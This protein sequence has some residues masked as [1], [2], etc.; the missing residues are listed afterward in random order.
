MNKNNKLKNST[1]KNLNFITN[2]KNTMTIFIKIKINN[3][4]PNPKSPN[5]ITNK[6]THKNS[7][8]KSH[9]SNNSSIN[10]K[11]STKIPHSIQN[12]NPYSITK[13]LFPTK[14][15]NI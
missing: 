12:P 13:F 10:S 9:Q 7:L 3:S 2:Q 6:N 8:N 4:A 5:I 11:S 15:M 1:K 14:K